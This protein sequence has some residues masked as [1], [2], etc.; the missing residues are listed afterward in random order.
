MFTFS[1]E[2]ELRQEDCSHN[3]QS[4]ELSA[5]TFSQL[6]SHTQTTCRA[7]DVFFA[8][9]LLCFIKDPEPS[10]HTFYSAVSRHH[11]KTWKFQAE[12]VSQISTHIKKGSTFCDLYRMDNYLYWP[13]ICFTSLVRNLGMA[14]V[15]WSTLDSICWWFV[16][17]LGPFG[18]VKHE[19]K[20]RPLGYVIGHGEPVL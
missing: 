12:N 7:V 20:P 2:R 1:D 4:V 14:A 13:A 10:R 15:H 8:M 6:H 11:L 5:V 16:R 3:E 9:H 18:I 19:V 17:L